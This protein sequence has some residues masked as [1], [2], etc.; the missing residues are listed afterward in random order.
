MRWDLGA[1]PLPEI[2]LPN[3]VATWPDP[4]SPTGRRINASL[5]APTRLERW[6]RGHFDELDGWSTT[7][8]IAI[9]FDGDLD[10]DE[11]RERQGKGR[12]SSADFQR[13]ALYLVDL[14]TG[15]PVPLELDHGFYP[16]FTAETDAYG[17]N[18]P[19]AREGNLLFETVEED[20]NG[21]GRLD[22][23][24]DLDFDGVLDHPNTDDRTWHRADPLLEQ[25]D[26]TIG[27]WEWESRTLLVRPLV[28]LRPRHTY[29]VVLTDRLLG[30]D[31]RPVRSPFDA[32]HPAQQYETL[33]PLEA[34]FRAHPE[35]YGDLADRGWEGVAFAWAFTTQSTYQD[36]EAL[37]EGLYGRGPFASL[38]ERFPPEAFPLPVRGGPGCT[39][40]NPFVMRPSDLR[41]LFDSL[42]E[43]DLGIPEDQVEPVL[44]ALEE[45]VSHLAFAFFES[46][47][48]LGDPEAESGYDTWDMDVRTGRLRVMRDRVPMMFV[49]PKETTEHR[50][51]FPTAFYAHGLGSLQIEPIAFAAQVA[52]QGVASVSIAAQGHG[53]PLGAGVTRLLT[54][55]LG[56]SCLAPLGR[57]LL[58]HRARDLDGDGVPDQA[59]RFFSAYMFHTRD[60]LRQTALDWL[61]AIR[62]VRSFFGAPGR[63]APRW[64]GGVLPIGGEEGTLFD[65]DLDGDGVPERAGDFD[66]DG[67]PDLGGWVGPHRMWGTS[68]GGLTTM[69]VAGLEPSIVATAPISGGGGLLDIGARTG[70]GPAREPVWMRVLGPALITLPSEGPSNESGCEA[71]RLGLLFETASLN[72]RHTVQMACLDPSELQ[73]GD[74]VVVRN[75]A[76]GEVRC[77]GVGPGGRVRV[78]IPTSGGDPLRVEVYRGFAERMDYASCTAPGMG[79]PVRVVDRWEVA[80]DETNSPGRCRQCAFYQGT[81][82]ERGSE[83]VAPTDGLGLPRQSPALRRIAMLSQLVVDPADPLNYAPRLFL[84]PPHAEDVP[85]RRPRGSM[86]VLTLGDD[87][88][89][90]ST[91]HAYARAAGILPF[92]P[93]DAPDVLADYRAPRTFAARFRAPSPADLLIDYHVTEGLSR[94]RRHPV[95]G[96]EHFVVDPDDLSEGK[97]WFDPSGRVQVPQ[98]SP[99]ATRPLRLD[100]PLRWARESRRIDGARDDPWRGTGSFPNYSAL[101]HLMVYPVGQHIVLP[102]DPRKPFDE[103]AYMLGAIGW[104]LASAGK[105]IPWHAMPSEHHCLEQTACIYGAD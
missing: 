30:A 78:V 21:N 13:H 54:T 43:L 38:A 28:P 20:R 100:P 65:G 80:H 2:P 74:A 40:D 46:P 101:A 16:F 68:L 26:R 105:E 91:G 61:Q 62:V 84:H 52:A 57:S 19:K 83:L 35:V 69:I 37:R 42:G 27:F 24:E 15:V 79:E 85:E 58:V 103:G 104:Y 31:G 92:L 82:W 94:L 70:L 23:G 45:H 77:A 73:E 12:F 34:H 33:R 29:A 90:V 63:D 41:V 47:Y 22:P 96:A 86:V 49:I 32:V 50:Q 98:G 1:E 17:R 99:G 89:P 55:L 66:G 10:L 71:G 67:T 5:I 53:V 102:T 7:G 72:R 44:E 81:E 39:V 3:D 76:N 11:L 64:P 56:R 88:V 18:D 48:L 51:P 93:A 97:Q 8:T 60:T 14:E 59:G 9:P 6:L 87:T 75:A 25:Y 95:P 36:L 4:T